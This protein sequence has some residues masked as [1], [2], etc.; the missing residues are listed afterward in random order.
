MLSSFWM[1]VVAAM[2][3]TKANMFSH[4]RPVKASSKARAFSAMTTM[5]KD[6]VL[7]G[8]FLSSDCI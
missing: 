1:S 7:V 3:Q 2:P 4:N 5:A 6:R 8:T